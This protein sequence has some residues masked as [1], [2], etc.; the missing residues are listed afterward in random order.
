MARY[1]V[2]FPENKKVNVKFK[3]F[4]VQTDQPKEAGGDET[5]PTPYDIFLSSLAACAGIFAISFFQRRK[6]NTDGFEM[7][8]D[9]KW[10]HEKHRLSKVMIHMKV[11]K[12]FPQKYINALKETVNLCSVKRTIADPPEFETFIE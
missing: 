1:T 11:P 10:D 12:D 8:M 6:L 5:A 2:T 4:E 9:I 3:D 7:F